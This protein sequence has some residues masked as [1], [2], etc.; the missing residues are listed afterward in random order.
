MTGNQIDQGLC[1]TCKNADKCSFSGNH[2]HPIFYCEEFE[3]K[4][5]FSGNKAEKNHPV[6]NEAFSD[7]NSKKIVVNNLKGLC[8][9]CKNR[10]T[11]TYPKPIGG[12]W[13]CNEYL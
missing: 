9:N 12:V 13:H 10:E 8:A 4:E 1:S 11:C 6:S 7:Y 2:R 5:F 3:Y